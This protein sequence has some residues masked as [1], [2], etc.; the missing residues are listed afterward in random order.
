MERKRLKCEKLPFFVGKLRVFISYLSEM[1]TVSM[2][3]NFS[4]FNCFLQL[5][6]TI[7]YF[8]DV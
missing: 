3:Y 5:V 8:G 4:L 7:F 2:F 1:K 6:S